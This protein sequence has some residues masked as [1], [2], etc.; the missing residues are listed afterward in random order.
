MKRRLCLTGFK[1]CL[2]WFSLAPPGTSDAVAQSNAG[3][4]ADAALPGVVRDPS[5]A[6]PYFGQFGGEYMAPQRP[7]SMCSATMCAT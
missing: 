4:A 1:T 2:L 3:R 7:A 6:F 5:G